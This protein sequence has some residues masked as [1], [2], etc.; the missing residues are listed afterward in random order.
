MSDARRTSSNYKVNNNKYLCYDSNTVS[1]IEPGM[2]EMPW[3]AKYGDRATVCDMTWKQLREK[4]YMPRLA[5]C[6]KE[7]ADFETAVDCSTR[8]RNLHDKC[9]TSGKWDGKKSF[10][11]VMREETLE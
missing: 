9:R 10:T 6:K 11:H 3:L 1:D 2:D 4:Y 7:N 5:A 8:I